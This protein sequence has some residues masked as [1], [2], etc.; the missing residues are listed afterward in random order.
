M[1]QQ[2]DEATQGTKRRGRTKTRDNK[3]T[4]EVEREKKI[5]NESEER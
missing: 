4:K 2:F 1:R 5:F 3:Q